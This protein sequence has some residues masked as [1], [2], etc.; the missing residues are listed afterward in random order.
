MAHDFKRAMSVL[1]SMFAQTPPESTMQDRAYTRSDGR[2]PAPT[3]TTLDG[4]EDLTPKVLR[5]VWHVADG[6]AVR[7]KVPAASTVAVVVEPRAKDEVG[8]N[9]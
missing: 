3:P 2:V 6:I 4:L 7:K 8:R 5:N 1:S 9:T